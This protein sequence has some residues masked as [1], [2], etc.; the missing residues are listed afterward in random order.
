MRAH[1]FL[2]NVVRRGPLTP[3]KVVTVSRAVLTSSGFLPQTEAIHQYNE[4]K[5]HGARAGRSSSG[6]R[7][8]PM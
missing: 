7:T 4:D 8:A 2:A 3:A 5:A 1:L 6:T